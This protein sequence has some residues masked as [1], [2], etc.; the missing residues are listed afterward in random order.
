[1]F[2]LKFLISIKPKLKKFM[3]SR[4]VSGRT[5]LLSNRIRNYINDAVD[6]TK[7]PTNI[8]NA[9]S[10]LLDGFLFNLEKTF[11]FFGLNH[12]PLF[13]PESKIKIFVNS[14]IVAYNCFYII[15][16]SLELIFDAELGHQL[17]TFLT[18]IAL[19]SWITEMLMEM[20]T[21]CYHHNHFVTDR[22]QIIKI[23]AKEYF[24]FEILPLLFEGRT[25]ENTFYNVLLH[26]PLL[27]KIK[28]MSIILAKLEFYILQVLERHYIF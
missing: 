22:K 12:L 20:N 21:V 5:T 6:Y 16:V 3:T 28:G 10:K 4:T 13:D 19:G 14:L 11:K 25:A 2:S 24:L 27:L 9:G 23:Y 7:Q 1:V 18:N 15:L 17:E 8:K 26:L